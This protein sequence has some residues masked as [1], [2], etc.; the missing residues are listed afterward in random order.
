MITFNSPERPVRFHMRPNK[1]VSEVSPVGK[2]TEEYLIAM[3]KRG[4]FIILLDPNRQYHL[5][6]DV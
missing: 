3:R 2:T 4:D 6:I 5:C 1:T